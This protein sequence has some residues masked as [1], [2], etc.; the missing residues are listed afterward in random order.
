MKENDDLLGMKSSEP[1]YTSDFSGFFILDTDTHECYLGLSESAWH[2]K[3]TTL[4]VVVPP[5]SLAPEPQV[6]EAISVENLEVE[7]IDTKESVDEPIEK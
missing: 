4:G 1:M 7:Q 6:S 3:L 5:I 2:D